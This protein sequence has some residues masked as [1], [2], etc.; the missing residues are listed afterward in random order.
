MPYPIFQVTAFLSKHPGGAQAIIHYAGG[1]LNA[2]KSFN[3]HSDEAKKKWRSL[4]VGVM[5]PCRCGNDDPCRACPYREEVPVGE[6]DGLRSPIPVARC[7]INKERCYQYSVCQKAL[8][9]A[10][11]EE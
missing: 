2:K 5:V 11:E 9:R 10:E 6:V 8:A 3:F 1:I 4:K 7:P